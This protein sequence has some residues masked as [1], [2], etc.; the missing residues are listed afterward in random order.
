[1]MSVPA[2]R[3]R[4]RACG[5]SQ[6][7]LPGGAA[8]TRY[9]QFIAVADTIYCAHTPMRLCGTLGGNMNRLAN[10]HVCTHMNNPAQVRSVPMA[11]RRR[12]RLPG[13]G[14]CHRMQVSLL[15]GFKEVHHDQSCTNCTRERFH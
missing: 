14:H 1:M 11:P 9:P 10:R 7:L 4:L 3:L 13:Q 12:R 15:P 2:P 6:R 5:P 8:L